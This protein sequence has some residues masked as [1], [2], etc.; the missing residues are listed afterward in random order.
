MGVL[1]QTAIYNEHDDNHTVCTVV[2][3]RV[4]NGGK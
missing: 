1:V 4:P 2:I 3:A